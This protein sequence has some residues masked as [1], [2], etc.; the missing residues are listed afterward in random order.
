MSDESTSNGPKDQPDPAA[1]EESLLVSM[2]G[3]E[4]VRV[5]AELPVLPVRDVVIYP[6]VTIPLVLKRLG[7]DPAL[8]GGV[9]LT[10]VTDVVGFMAFLGLGALLLT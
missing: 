8:A 7:I 4:S 10:T 9:I 5:P 1:G 6:G 3:D 2:P